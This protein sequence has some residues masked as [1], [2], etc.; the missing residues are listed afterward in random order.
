M[1][2]FGE[3]GSG[4]AG[5]TGPLLGTCCSLGT[6]IDGPPVSVEIST[7]GLAFDCVVVTVVVRCRPMLRSE[8]VERVLRV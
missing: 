7:E 8:V 5:L 3:F 1:E 2:G 6:V 4:P